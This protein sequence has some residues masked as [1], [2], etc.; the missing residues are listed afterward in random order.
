MRW[1]IDSTHYEFKMG[2]YEFK[3][4]SSEFKTGRG[5]L[6]RRP[7]GANGSAAPIRHSVDRRRI[8]GRIAPGK[9]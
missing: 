5:N 4:G 6:C 3:M 7:R 9:R 1:V 2:H 8:A